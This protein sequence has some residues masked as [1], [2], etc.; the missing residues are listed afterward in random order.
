[1]SGF[2]TKKPSRAVERGSQTTH[3]SF[4]IDLVEEQVES[5]C[6]SNAKL[7]RLVEDREEE[8]IEKQQ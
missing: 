5:I 7:S 4:I 1:V 2:A 8:L 6:R 3:K